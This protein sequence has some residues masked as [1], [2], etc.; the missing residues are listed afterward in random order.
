MIAKMQQ[1]IVDDDF[2]LLG[3]L[4]FD[5]DCEGLESQIDLK[6]YEGKA[7]QMQAATP[8]WKWLQSKCN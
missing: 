3:E 8:Q 2:Q 4:V 5:A 6:W 7:S 1:A